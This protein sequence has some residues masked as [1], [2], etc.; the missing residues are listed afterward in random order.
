MSTIT[1][2]TQFATLHQHPLFVDI[3]LLHLATSEYPVICL[4]ANLIESISATGRGIADR[5]TLLKPSGFLD[6]FPVSCLSLAVPGVLAC[7]SHPCVKHIDVN[8]LA[9]VCGLRFILICTA[10]RY[11]C[12]SLPYFPDCHLEYS[13]HY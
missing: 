5:S 8:Q 2:H 12:K 10:Y 7:W 6:V 1:L 4:L 13:T 11:S 9:T 3:H